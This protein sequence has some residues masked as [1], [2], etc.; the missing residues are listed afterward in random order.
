[1]AWYS[2][3]IVSAVIGGVAGAFLTSAVSLYI[4]RKTHK[5]RR[6]DGIVVE[7]SSLLT[8]SE[9]IKDKLQVNFESQEAKSVYLINFDIVN[10]GTEAILN[11]PVHLRL[12]SHAK[13]VDYTT[14]T[15]P[16]VGFGA[17]NE[18]IKN[19]NALDLEIELLNP[20]DRVSVEVVSLDN[21]SEKVEIYLKNENVQSR[22]YT[23]KSAESE[24]FGAISDRE[25][26][27]LAW[28]SFWPFLGGMARA[29]MTISLGK[30]IDKISNKT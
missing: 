2:N 11:Q 6:V 8:F 9:K 16:D 1:M 12:E 7:V 13:I 30:R 28:M 19:G 3:P 23:R 14:K 18:K 24:L 20:A 29:M 21:E 17:I 27:L 15:K 5:L 22:V 26:F 25:M 4:W 10:T